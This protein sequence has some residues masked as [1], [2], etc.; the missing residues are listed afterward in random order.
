MVSCSNITGGCKAVRYWTFM[1]IFPFRKYLIGLLLF[2]LINLSIADGYGQNSTTERAQAYSMDES[3]R[4]Y[5]PGQQPV[6]VPPITF[7]DVN[8]GRFGKLEIDLEDGQFFDTAVDKLHLIATGLDVREGILKSLDIIIHGGHIQDFTF[9]QFNMSTETSVNFDSG[10][11]LNHR[12]L[13][14]TQPI[15]TEVSA[16]ITQDSLNRF[17]NSPKTL[18]RLSITANGRQLHCQYGWSQPRHFRT[19]SC[20]SKLSN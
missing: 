17:L 2:L 8:S 15:Q 7:V 11:L 1:M 12:I 5:Q 10:A 3:L 6:V 9:D 19:D 18:A 20:V 14:F 4:R 13:Q 16:I